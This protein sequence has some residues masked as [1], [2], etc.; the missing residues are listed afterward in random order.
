MQKEELKTN[1]KKEIN[2]DIITVKTLTSYWKSLPVQKK[3]IGFYSDKSTF[4]PYFSNFYVQ[5]TPFTFK[6]PEWCGM[7][8]NEEIRIKFSE[9]AIMLCKA[10]LMN[11]LDAYENIKNCNTPEETKKLGRTV[12]P[13]NQELWDKNICY[14]AREVTLAK[15]SQNEEYKYALLATENYL[16]AEAAPRDKIWG[17]GMGVK[18]PELINP[19]KWKGSNILGWALMEVRNKLK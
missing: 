8:A 10:S 2:D 15:F 3:V 16:I 19:T 1:S 11:D 13:W 14:I 7:M 12:S 4:F 5:N 9:K 17:I 6:I 18:N